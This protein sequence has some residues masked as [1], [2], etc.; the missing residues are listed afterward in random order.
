MRCL[1][2]LRRCSSRCARMAQ[3]RSNLAA[4]RCIPARSLLIERR[5]YCNNRD[6]RSAHSP[7]PGGE[8]WGWVREVV[9]FSRRIPER[10]SSSKRHLPTPHPALPHK[11]GGKSTRKLGHDAI[12]PRLAFEA[13]AGAIAQREIAVLELGIVGK[14]A[15]IAEHAGIGLGAAEAEAGGD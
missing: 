13:D 11:G 6:D 15:K 8:G 1:T 9:H 10:P 14:T 4:S 7:P 12:K 3:P 5:D 2:A